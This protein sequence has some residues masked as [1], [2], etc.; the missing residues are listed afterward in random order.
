MKNLKVSVEEVNLEETKTAFQKLSNLLSTGYK[1]EHSFGKRS[2][3]L[4][5]IKKVHITEK[6]VEEDE[7]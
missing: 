5:L 2:E 6:E 1:I 3:R 7:D 4:L